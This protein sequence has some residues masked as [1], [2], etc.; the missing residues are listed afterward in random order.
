MSVLLLNYMLILR[1]WN[2]LLCSMNRNVDIPIGNSGG[3]GDGKQC[4]C[5]LSCTHTPA[6]WSDPRLAPSNRR[7]RQPMQLM[8]HPHLPPPLPPPPIGSFI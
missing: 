4:R 7:P 6:D 1:C 2:A 3:E 5:I 8:A